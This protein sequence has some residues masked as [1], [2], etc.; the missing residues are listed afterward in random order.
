MWQFDFLSL[1]ISFLYLQITTNRSCRN[2]LSPEGKPEGRAIC[3][4]W[5]F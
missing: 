5:S 3:D 1:Y 2:G 4:R